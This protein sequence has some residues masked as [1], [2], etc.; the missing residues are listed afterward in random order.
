M[1]E[2]IKDIFA[3]IDRKDAEGFVSFLTVDASFRFANAP[4]MR[5]RKAIREGVGLF[6]TGIKKL[7]HRI[8]GI[9]E[10]DGMIICEGEVTYTR[11]DDSALT[12]PFVDILRLKGELVFDYRVYMD[13]SPLGLNP[14]PE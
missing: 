3:A 12:L 2:R 11:H 6:F 5:N 1:N 8:S 10:Q 14:E 4:V 7:R 9:W 13:I